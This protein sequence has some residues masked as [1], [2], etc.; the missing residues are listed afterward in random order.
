MM[1]SSVES[2]YSARWFRR[3]SGLLYFGRFSL[4]ASVRNSA[5]IACDFRSTAFTTPA[6]VPKYAFPPAIAGDENTNSPVPSWKT[7]APVFAS[8]AWNRL[9][10]KS[11]NRH[12][13]SFVIELPFLS[14]GRS[15]HRVQIRI[16]AAEINDPVRHHRR[17]L[18][19]HLVVNLGIFS[20]LESPYGF[21][22]RGVKRVQIRIPRA[23]IHTTA[24]DSR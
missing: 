17:R 3:P 15:V 22:G 12:A 24:V 5:A 13:G 20:G 14:A 21:P 4:L 7:G 2:G 9:C 23:D 8:R 16:P 6:C 10:R 1:P 11:R 19:T 18:D